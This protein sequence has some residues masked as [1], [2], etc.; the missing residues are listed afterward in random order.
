MSMNTDGILFYGVHLYEPNS[1]ESNPT[2]L[3]DFESAWDF[4]K[5]IEVRLG[6]DAAVKPLMYCCDSDPII[7]LV[8]KESIIRS[9]RG[10]LSPFDP[11]LHKG[12]WDNWFVKLDKA[13]ERLGTQMDAK[14]AWF[15][16]SWS[17]L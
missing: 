12:E 6:K 1:E 3:G 5:A 4:Q 2:N 10:D 7:A 16:T 13:F 17:D 15:V 11:E 9:R 14:P 8:I